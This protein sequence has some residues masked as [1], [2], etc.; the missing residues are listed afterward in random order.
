MW[1]LV[2]KEG[3][4]LKNW[5]FQIVVLEKTLKSSLDCKEIKPVNPKGNQPWV[6]I[7]RADAEAPNFG[8]LMWGANSLEKTLMLGKTEGNRR[9]GWQR[10]RWLDSITVSTDM[11]LSNSEWQELWYAVV[12]GIAKSQIWFSNNYSKKIN[13]LWILAVNQL[14]F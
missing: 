8:H 14:Y 6:F 10:M 4:V 9:S 3:W 12:H 2:H 7:G 1:E 5:C 11:N 13:P